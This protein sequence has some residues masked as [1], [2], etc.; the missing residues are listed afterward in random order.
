VRSADD[1]DGAAVARSE[2]A[3]DRHVQV[4]EGFELAGV[5]QRAG[6]DRALAGDLAG[7]L[8]RSTYGE[9]STARR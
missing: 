5:G 6:V 9:Q 4:A 3:L 7:E 8:L 2:P 1:L